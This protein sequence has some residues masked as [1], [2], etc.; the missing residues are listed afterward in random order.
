MRNMSSSSPNSALQQ[1]RLRQAW[2]QQD[3]ADRLGT[4][5][6]TV[7]RWERGI[8]VASPYFRLKLCTLLGKDPQA[9]GLLPGENNQPPQQAS[10]D[11]PARPE[12]VVRPWNL[13]FRRNPF[14]TGREATLAKLRGMLL[15]QKTIAITP[16]YA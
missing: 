4:T 14:F 11:P 10:S 12:E 1:E 5:K 7:G 3:L 2:T 9:L 8:T 16:G 15:A 13:P 6:L